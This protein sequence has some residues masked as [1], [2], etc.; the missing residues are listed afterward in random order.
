MRRINIDHVCTDID[1]PTTSAERF[2]LLARCPKM[3]ETL[4]ASEA[5][6]PHF[7]KGN[8]MQTT[9]T[10]VCFD[11]VTLLSLCHVRRNTRNPIPVF[12]SFHTEGGIKEDPVIAAGTDLD[13]PAKNVPFLLLG[14]RLFTGNVHYFGSS[15]PGS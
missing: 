5:S 14:T 3:V 6:L 8:E 2:S 10:L 12:P 15:S 9:F 1:V 7:V 4:Q 11:D 13:K